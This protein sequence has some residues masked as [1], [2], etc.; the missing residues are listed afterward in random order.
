MLFELFASVRDR[1]EHASLFRTLLSGPLPGLML[2]DMSPQSRSIEVSHIWQV[3]DE[4]LLAVPQV[5]RMA[6]GLP[7]VL[8]VFLL[9]G[10]F[11]RMLLKFR[12]WL[13]VCCR[14]KVFNFR[15]CVARFKRVVVGWC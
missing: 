6:F 3:Y 2:L 10:E 9:V 15:H 14:I 8:V 11:G 13:E 4:Q 5:C 1:L 7:W 12:C